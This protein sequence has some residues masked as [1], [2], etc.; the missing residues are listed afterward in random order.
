MAIINGNNNPNTLNGE[1][2]IDVLDGGLGADSMR[3]GKC[4]TNALNGISQHRGQVS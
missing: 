4:T 3:G 2:G 1:D